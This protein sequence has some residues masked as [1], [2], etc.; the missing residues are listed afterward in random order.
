M[1]T[2]ISPAVLH[3]LLSSFKT[4]YI[5]VED[6]LCYAKS[7]PSNAN[8]GLTD[9]MDTVSGQQLD[10][11]NPG[12]YSQNLQSV[13]GSKEFR[14]CAGLRTGGDEYTRYYLL[15]FFNRTFRVYKVIVHV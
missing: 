10:S 4:D 9:I 8:C 1:Y 3:F 14:F 11:G 13:E 15:V 7:S 6:G 2:R 12:L 5:I